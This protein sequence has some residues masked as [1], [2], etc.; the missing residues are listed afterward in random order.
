M[1]L[2]NQQ[3]VVMMIQNIMMIQLVLLY[4]LVAKLMMELNVQLVKQIIRNMILE[5]LEIQKFVVIIMLI[6]D[7]GTKMVLMK[8]HVQKWGKVL[9]LDQYHLIIQMIAI[10]FWQI[11]ILQIIMEMIL[12]MLHVLNVKQIIILVVIYNKN[13]VKREKC[14][15]EQLK[16][17]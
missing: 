15:M 17:V 6:Q 3:Y 13:V 14:G 10:V 5:I 1:E 4:L 7:S 11:L 16:Y 12:T 2:I 8:L 9:L